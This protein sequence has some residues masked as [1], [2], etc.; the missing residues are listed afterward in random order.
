MST[1]KI[2]SLAL[3]VV[4][5]VL[6]ATFAMLLMTWLLPALIGAPTW[7][8]NSTWYLTAAAMGVLLLFVVKLLKEWMSRHEENGLIRELSWFLA[9]LSPLLFAFLAGMAGLQL[10]VLYQRDLLFSDHGASVAFFVLFA[11][12]FAL[13]KQRRV[14][15]LDQPERI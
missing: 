9:W 12:A 10:L 15:A 13:A 1:P 14:A 6:A 2:L 3:S 5:T 11:L 8:E 7:S 4:S